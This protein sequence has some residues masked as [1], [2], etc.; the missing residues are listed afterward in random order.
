MKTLKNSILTTTLFFLISLTFY[1][2]NAI[3]GG[4]TNWTHGEVPLLFSDYISREKIIM[5]NIASNGHMTIPLDDN[6]LSNF[7]IA[8]EKAKEN[9]RKGWE[10]KFNTVESTFGSGEEG[11]I[12]ENAASVLI[13]LP[14]L[15][16][17]S[18]DGTAQFGYIYCTNNPELANWLYNYGQGDIAKGYYLRWFFAEDTATVKGAFSIPVY[19]GNDDENYTDT[20]FYDIELQKGWNIIKYNITEIFTTQT[21]KTVLSKM[22]VTSIYEMPED[23]MWLVL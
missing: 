5:G 8:A 11:I 18:E 15:E 10:M 2:Q 21:G 22:E 23:V 3:T 12:Y 9:A 14:D 17:T 1:A 20:T 7:K 16:A 13:G 19:T 4:I 6:F